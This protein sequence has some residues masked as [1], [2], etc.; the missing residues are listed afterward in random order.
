MKWKRHLES[1]AL[2]CTI[3]GLLGEL[4]ILTEILIYKQVLFVEPNTTVLLLEILG[5]IYALA[6]NVKEAVKR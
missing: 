2:G 5:L 1:I 3:G 6:Y 4:Y